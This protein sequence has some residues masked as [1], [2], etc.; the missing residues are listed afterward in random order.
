MAAPAQGPPGSTG[1]AP[2][3]VS[4]RAKVVLLPRFCTLCC[5]AG[6]SNGQDAVSNRL[7][8][9]DIREGGKCQGKAFHEETLV[10]MGFWPE[11]SAM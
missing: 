1:T 7:D 10:I 5:L 9:Q 2:A 8:V 3:A 6:P 4:I 11:V